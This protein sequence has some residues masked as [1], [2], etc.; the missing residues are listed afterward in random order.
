MCLEERIERGVCGMIE[1][2]VVLFSPPKCI[3]L[4][5]ICIVGMTV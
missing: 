3:L 5:E 1:C 2:P 4:S